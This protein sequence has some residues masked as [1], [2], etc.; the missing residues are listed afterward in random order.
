MNY[1]ERARQ[2]ANIYR[3]SVLDHSRKTLSL[4]D[5]IADEFKAVARE[6]R[7]QLRQDLKDKAK[8]ESNS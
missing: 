6:A 5:L 3:Q 7:K 1:K 8:N 4:E 2:V